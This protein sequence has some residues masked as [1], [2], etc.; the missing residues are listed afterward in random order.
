MKC[1]SV[2]KG[3]ARGP[4]EHGGGEPDHS[5]GQGLQ[6]L[7]NLREASRRMLNEP[8]SPT[9][10]NL[11]GEQYQKNPAFPSKKT[12]VHTHFAGSAAST[13]SSAPRR[14]QACGSLVIRAMRPS[15]CSNARRMR[16][17]APLAGCSVDRSASGGMPKGIRTHQRSWNR[18]HC[19]SSCTQVS[20]R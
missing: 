12:Q 20:S 5:L 4:P 6:T 10:T 3:P 9:S 15:E 8:A 19:P 11:G 1:N 13:V 2:W 16:D 17:R 7:E 14:T 18:H